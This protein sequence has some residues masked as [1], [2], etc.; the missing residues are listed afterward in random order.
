MPSKSL[1]YPEGEWPDDE[2]AGH[3][4]YDPGQPKTPEDLLTD[5]GRDQQQEERNEDRGR[6]A[7]CCRRR[8]MCK[9]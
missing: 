3:L 9:R 5:L 1:T 2:T 8:R 4:S 7:G 6:L